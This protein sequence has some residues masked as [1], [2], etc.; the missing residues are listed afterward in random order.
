MKQRTVLVVS[1]NFPPSQIASVHRARH[2]AKHLPKFGWTPVVITVDERYH[3]EPIDPDLGGLVSST[4]VHRVNALPLNL[5]APLGLGDLSLRSWFA[6]RSKLQTL[7]K[8]RGADL[9][10]ITG[11]PFYQMLLSVEIAA[12][13]IPVVLDFQDPWVSAWGAMQPSWSKAGLTQL[14]AK[15]LEP[16]ALRGA[17]F[18]TSVSETQNADLVARYP[19]LDASHMAAI[20]IGGDP[21]D[22][23][24]LRRQRTCRAGDLLQEGKFNLSFIG[25]FMPRSGPLIRLVLEALRRLQCEEPAIAHR[26]RMNFVGTSNQADDRT[27][28]RVMPIAREIGLESQ[29]FETP[30]RIPFLQALSV[31]VNSD[32]ILLV[33][34]DEAHYT[35]SKIY[36]ALMCGRPFLSF[37]HE[38]SSSHSILASAGGGFAH[39]YSPNRPGSEMIADLADSLRHLVESPHGLGRIDPAVCAP[40]EAKA[41]AERF[42]GIFS[43]LTTGKCMDYRSTQS[44]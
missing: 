40:Y 2:L 28:Y 38:A 26:I 7:I 34:S 8:Q 41:I 22:F 11:W 3:K 12:A 43:D 37:F 24:Q 18:V 44:L 30:Q 15:I 33:G 21:D 35:A 31:L 10:F 4:E 36:P 27:T 42:A 9:V 1:L 5:T 32:A 39:A 20:P 17:S 25:T 29:V 13:G 6:V 19:W 16:Q 14:L 23:E